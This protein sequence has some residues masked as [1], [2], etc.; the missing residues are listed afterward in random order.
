MPV[1]NG[2]LFIISES[3]CETIGYGIRLIAGFKIPGVVIH[4]NILRLT[5][6]LEHLEDLGLIRERL[7]LIFVFEL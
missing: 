1:E 7:F 5:L 2:R 3:S 6:L 4:K